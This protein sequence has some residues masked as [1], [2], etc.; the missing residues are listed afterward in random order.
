[1]GKKL[2]FDK[3]LSIDD[4]LSCGSCHLPKKGWSNGQPFATGVNG[5]QSSRS[6]PA[7]FNSAYNHSQFWDGR[8]ATLEDQVLDPILNPVEMGM[9]SRSVLVAKLEKDAEYRRLFAGVFPD[10]IT[11]E[12]ISKAIASFERT[13]LS[14]NA[15][16]DRYRAGDKKALSESAIRGMEV[17]FNIA[18]CSSCHSG[19][20]FTDFSFHSVGIGMD[21]PNPDIG[22]QA[23][24]GIL[25]DRGAFKTPTLREV[26][27]T[28]PYMHDG[29][30]ATLADVVDYYDRGGISHDQ[31]DARIHPLGLTSQQKQDLVMFL[32]EALRGLQ[33]HS[34]GG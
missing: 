9:P 24:S 22:R 5:G 29:S 18:N 3:R 7:L 27:R 17:F 12:N 23:I 25:S 11:A 15:P 10:G 34:D 28:A 2:F 33:H 13:I 30:L 32:T 14:G 16:Y 1:M 6:V 4:S 8:V 26:A 21:R 19:P 20:N 31:L